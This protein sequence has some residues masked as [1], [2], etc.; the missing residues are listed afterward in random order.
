MQLTKQEISDLWEA[1][2]GIMNNWFDSYQY[3]T[4]TEEDDALF[5]RW[6]IIND[7]LRIA[8]FGE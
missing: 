6:K 2:N 7:K 1:T 3:G 8:K 4:L 5:E